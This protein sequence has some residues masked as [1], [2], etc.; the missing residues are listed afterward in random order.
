MNYNLNLKNK[1]IC[2][3]G[4]SGIIGSQLVKFLLD[5]DCN[6]K[7]LS[8]KSYHSPSKKIKIFIG[9]LSNP[10]LNLEPFVKNCDY[11]IN[12]AAELNNIKLMHMVN[13]QSV[14]R[15]L[16]AIN[17]TSNYKSKKVHWIQL[18]SCGVYG[19][20]KK[21][22]DSDEKFINEDF[23]PNPQNEYEKTKLYA[24]KIL[25][26]SAK[27]N[28][29]DYTILR[30][31]NVIS[32]MKHANIFYRLN[33]LIK[34]NFFF[35]LDFKNSIATYVHIDD[36]VN[37][38]VEIICNQKS[39]NNIFN[40]SLNCNWSKIIDKIYNLNK[41]KQPT[42][43][44]DHRITTLLVL[45]RAILGNF[46]YIPTLR[47]FILRNNFQ[48]TKIEELLGFKFKKLLPEN[49]ENF[50]PKETNIK[51]KINSLEKEIN[52]KK[53]KDLTIQ[54]NNDILVS[55][56]MAVYN[57][58][59]FLVKSIESILCQTLKNFEFIIVNDGS[60]DS[61]LKIIQEFSKKDSRIRV[62]NKL[63]SGLT[64][65]LN[66]GIDV[67]RGEW[68]ARIDADDIASKNRLMEQYIR[69]IGDDSLVLIG[70]SCWEI[71]EFENKI[72]KF[73]Y[74]ENHNDLKKN[75]IRMK[76]HFPHSS[77]FIKTKILKNINGYKVR[78][79]RAQD[80]DLS[81][82]LSKFG[83]ITNISKPLIFLR[84]H[85]NSISF[86]DQ[87]NQQIIYPRLSLINYHMNNLSLL[88]PLDENISHKDFL[89]LLNI[90]RNQ[91]NSFSSNI[92][93]SI[94][95]ILINKNR[96]NFFSNQRFSIRDKNEV[97]DK[98]FKISFSE[99]SN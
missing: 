39:K 76:N 2:I 50:F 64:H 60:T 55:V 22:Y 66:C 18:S 26:N 71:D 95:K 9:D 86:S 79:K 11:F 1:T 59:K 82:R 78:M 33:L 25:I 62:I 37:S 38:I 15:L 97:L 42:I 16:T 85:K 13:T 84:R 46:F 61:S 69:G 87:I 41:I 5:Y 70:S 12:C 3:T 40:L 28:I 31:S 27:K 91:Y 53:L 17:K 94:I 72:K 49:V 52:I 74:P 89:N 83:N 48:S 80:Y 75:L 98:C 54:S 68:I 93:S 32:N 10:I 96:Y 21:F 51:K 19:S 45:L 34:K 36:L 77:Y 29:I 65:S 4:A 63:N 7:I 35:K 24:D 90:V 47:T 20:D 99:I 56:V 43:S 58:E 44:I 67:A 81:L 57:G 30:P 88:G 92:F 23:E 14:N 6:I 8:R 73:D